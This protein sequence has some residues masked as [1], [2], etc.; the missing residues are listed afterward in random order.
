MFNHGSLVREVKYKKV[1]SY[2]MASK[3]SRF[4]TLLWW[5]SAHAHVSNDYVDF[6]FH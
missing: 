6:S 1:K 2:A 5:V 3:Y 4:I